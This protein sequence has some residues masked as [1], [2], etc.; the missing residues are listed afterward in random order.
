V[1]AGLTIVAGTL[2]V[3]GGLLPLALIALGAWALVTV[4]R[5]RR[6]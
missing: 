3:L 1:S 2:V 5:R 4:A 6:V